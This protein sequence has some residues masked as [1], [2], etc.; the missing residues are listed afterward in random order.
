MPGVDDAFSPYSV[1]GVFEEVPFSEVRRG[2]PV[3]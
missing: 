3:G 1:F 2:S